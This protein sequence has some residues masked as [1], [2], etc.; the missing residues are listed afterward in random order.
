MLAVY[1]DKEGVDLY[2][3]TQQVLKAKFLNKLVSIE[4]EVK[5]YSNNQNPLTKTE[6]GPSVTGFVIDVD[7]RTGAEFQDYEIYLELDEYPDEMDIHDMYDYPLTLPV[8]IWAEKSETYKEYHKKKI[9][10]RFDL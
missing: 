10:R 9:Q 7:C 2:D 5:F 6:R 4:T 3:I 8:K 1:A